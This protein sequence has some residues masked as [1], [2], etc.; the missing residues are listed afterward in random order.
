MG[1]TPAMP[2]DTEISE[3]RYVGPRAAGG[4]GCA[5]RRAI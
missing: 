3:R 4:V 5:G 2:F 1:P